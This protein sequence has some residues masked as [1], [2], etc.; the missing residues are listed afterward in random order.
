MC[1]VIKDEGEKVS[2]CVCER[3][4]IVIKDEGKKKELCCAFSPF[5][6]S[7]LSLLFVFVCL[8]SSLFVWV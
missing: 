1:I 8:C 2:N 4:Y 3:V 6:P 7:S 5:F